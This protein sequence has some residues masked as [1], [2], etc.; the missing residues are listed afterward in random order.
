[1]PPI[2]QGLTHY[3]GTAIL[4]V[5]YVGHAFGVQHIPWVRKHEYMNRQN[6]T[7]VCRS[8]TDISLFQGLPH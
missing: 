1:M 5:C 6:N 4:Y 2:F 8:A 3:V 7:F